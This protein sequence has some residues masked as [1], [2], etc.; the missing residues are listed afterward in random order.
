[1][2]K[3]KAIKKQCCGSCGSENLRGGVRFRPKD[4]RDYFAS[5]VAS[6]VTD[7]NVIMRLLRHTSLTTTTKYLRTVKDRMQEAVKLLGASLGGKSGGKFLPKTTQN[8]ISGV[9]AR[10][11]ITPQ[12]SW[13][14][15]GGGGRTRTVD[16]ADMSRVL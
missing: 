12:D 6:Q 2:C 16:S 10:M 9:P 4:L 1:M 5:E 14:N 8:D 11:E 13:R 15:Y 3:A 7:P